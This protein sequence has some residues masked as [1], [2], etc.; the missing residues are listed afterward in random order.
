MSTR[1]AL[2]SRHGG[3][4]LVEVVVALAVTGLLMLVLYDGLHLGMRSWAGGMDRSER[5]EA[6][7]RLER[8]MRGQLARVHLPVGAADGLAGG[9]RYRGEPTRMRFVGR[10]SGHAG[11]GGA[12]GFDLGVERGRHGMRLTVRYALDAAYAGAPGAPPESHH[13]VLLDDIGAVRFSYFGVD[14]HG[15]WQWSDRWDRA[16]VLPTLVRVEVDANEGRWP[17]MVFPVREADRWVPTVN[18]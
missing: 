2:V 3:F 1:P 12:Y 15:R 8:F 4:T 14:E 11:R 16:R 18:P 6:L 5:S 7:R 13:E 9:P 10:L 17:A